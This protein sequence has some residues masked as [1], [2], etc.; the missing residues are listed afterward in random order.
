MDIFLVI[1]ISIFLYTSDLLARYIYTRTNP[2]TTIIP[3]NVRWFFIHSLSNGIIAY[4]GTGDVIYCLYNTNT[5]AFQS[6]DNSGSIALLF[7]LL[8]HIYHIVF[9]YN[10]LTSSEWLH[11]G[12]MIG[13]AGPMSFYHPSRATIVSLCFLTGYPGMID[14]AMLW[15]VKMNWLAKKSERLYNSKINIWIRSPGCMFAVFLSIPL[16]IKGNILPIIMAT[17]CFWNAQY[18]MSLAINANYLLTAGN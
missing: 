5:C 11:H 9:F 1:F 3:H 12:L 4:L 2:T 14:Y 6:W 10:Y 17:L 13:I 15:C 7:S 8:F 18:Y 16:I